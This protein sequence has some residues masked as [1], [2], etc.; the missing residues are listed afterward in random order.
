MKKKN[1]LIAF[2]MLL[3]TG[4]ALSTA[5]YA[6][7]TANTQ[8]QLGRID[9]QVQATNGIQVSTD[10]SDWKATLTTEQI[11]NAYYSGGGKTSVTQFPD[12]TNGDYLQPVSTDGT[13]VN[14][15]FDMY[16]GELQEDGTITLTNATEIAGS[17]IVPAADSSA[18]CNTAGG[19]WDAGTTTCT[20][21]SVHSP[22]A[23]TAA[24][25]SWAESSTA[26]FIAFDL[27]IQ[28]SGAAALEV[29]LLPSSAV[30]VPTGTDAGLKSSIRV[31]FVNNG[32]D[33]TNTANTA[34]GLSESTNY[35]IWEPNAEVHTPTAIAQGHAVGG[36][37]YSYMGATATGTAVV[38]NNATQFASVPVGS[39]VVVSTNSSKANFVRDTSMTTET[40][41]TTQVWNTNATTNYPT[42]FSVSQGINKIRVY[43]W[44]EG[45]DVD[46][47][48]SATLGNA[49]GVTINLN[50]K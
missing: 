18:T 27:F 25:T 5:S 7:F 20:I 21:T 10:A 42:V 16:Y 33:A 14:G 50:A 31:A 8:I 4:V 41:P 37:K 47:E 13:L 36:Q 30:S 49:V 6:W 28:S 32:V 9:V 2:L 48:N 44:I 17:C 43:I 12:V 22:S 38:I 24:G 39:G 23:C 15:K 1:I 29:G 34:Y 26:Y 40:F 45:Q 3:L 35:T 46:C 11:R 19:T